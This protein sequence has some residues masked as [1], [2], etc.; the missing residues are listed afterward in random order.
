MSLES[1]REEVREILDL[2]TA[3]LHERLEQ[4]RSELLP[5]EMHG[6]KP[7]LLI[8]YFLIVKPKIARQ[9][10]LSESSTWDEIF[11]TS[12]RNRTTRL[13]LILAGIGL[14][15]VELGH[16]PFISAGEMIKLKEDTAKALKIANASMYAIRW[17]RY[18]KFWPS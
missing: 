13:K 9:R 7:S 10:G 6:Q 12:C 4:L 8:S 14:N 5:I 18:K 16:S 15:A 3:L 1:H 17:E 11:P 2:D